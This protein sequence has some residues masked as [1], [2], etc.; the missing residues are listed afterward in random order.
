MGIAIVFSMAGTGVVVG[1]I[2]AGIGLIP[3]MPTCGRRSGGAP[4]TLRASSHP[5]SSAWLTWR[6]LTRYMPFVPLQVK[7]LLLNA[8]GVFILL[9]FLAQLFAIDGL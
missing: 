3:Q 5:R 6:R 9:G 4:S 1:G 8:A 2:V 7:R